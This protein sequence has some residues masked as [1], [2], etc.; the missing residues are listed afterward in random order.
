[1]TPR[2]R[3]SSTDMLSRLAPLAAGIALAATACGTPP[4]PGNFP[5]HAEPDQTTTRPIPTRRVEKAPLDVEQWELTGPLP[6]AY[7]AAPATG[8][9][10]WSKL[11]ADGITAMGKP[12]LVVTTAA[13]TCPARELAAFLAVKDAAPAEPLRG[14]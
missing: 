5:T 4:K 7:D 13:M 2:A 8:D 1:M 14:F 11:L 3:R 9:S 6:E 12:G 10:A